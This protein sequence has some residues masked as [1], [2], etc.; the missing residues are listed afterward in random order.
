MRK[1]TIKA[2]ASYHIAFISCTGIKQEFERIDLL[3]RHHMLE[4]VR[5]R[6]VVLFA[7]I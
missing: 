4:I 3:C 6:N 1:A 7:V 2:E 5:F